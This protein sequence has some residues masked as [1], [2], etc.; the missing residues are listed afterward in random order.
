VLFRTDVHALGVIL[1]ELLTGESPHEKHDTEEQLQRRIVKGPR[2]EVGQ[3]NP[4]IDADLAKIVEQA[5]AVDAKDRF[6]TPAAL[7][8]ALDGWLPKAGAAE[9]AAKHIS[10]HAEGGSVAIGGNNTNSPIHISSTKP[11]AH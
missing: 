11:A 1:F 3:V 5:M 9:T 6:A 7:A 10:V 2:R 4:E 8:A